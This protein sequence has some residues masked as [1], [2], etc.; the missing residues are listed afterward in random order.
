MDSSI[1][2]AVVG[3]LAAPIA[4]FMTWLFNRKKN[5]ADIYNVIA[6]ASGEAV[7]TMQATMQE[8]RIELSEARAK[9]EE[10]IT[11]NELLREDLAALKTQNETLMIQIH[12]MR[13]A[14]EQNQ[15]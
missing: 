1:I 12:D 2:I 14:Y 8:L 15:P 13:V 11:E 10:L 6:G 9:I 4:A 3:V 7:E 5:I